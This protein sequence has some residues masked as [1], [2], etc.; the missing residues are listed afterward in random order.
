MGMLAGVDLPSESKTEI[1]E[2]LAGRGIL[3]DT[4]SAAREAG[5][6]SIRVEV[7]ASLSTYLP[8][9]GLVPSGSKYLGDIV[10]AFKQ[11]Y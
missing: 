9:L 1:A 7:I 8:T 2:L 4:V 11:L 5:A 6:G 3:A 10:A